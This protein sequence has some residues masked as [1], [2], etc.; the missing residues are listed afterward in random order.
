VIKAEATV[1]DLRGGRPGRP[2]A[3]K[4]VL[5]VDRRC[6]RGRSRDSLVVRTND[7]IKEEIKL[8]IRGTVL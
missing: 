3:V 7:P 5:T 2:G 4:L 8:P 6:G 1:P